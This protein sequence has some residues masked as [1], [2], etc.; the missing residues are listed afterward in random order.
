[1]DKRKKTR[2]NKTRI[3]PSKTNIRT[4]MEYH[5]E[6]SEYPPIRS[7]KKMS[8]NAKAARESSADQI[9]IDSE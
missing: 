6:K 1:M 5:R 2:H 4:S 9:S 3:E 8:R 7:K